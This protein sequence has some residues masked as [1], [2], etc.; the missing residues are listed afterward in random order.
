M[1]CVFK[2]SAGAADGG[3]WTAGGGSAAG[4]QFTVSG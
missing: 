3:G 1:L 2:T 4:D